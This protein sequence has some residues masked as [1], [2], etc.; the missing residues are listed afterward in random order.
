MFLH[1]ALLLIHIINCGR[2]KQH[3][4][5]NDAI[6]DVF[7]DL[8]LDEIAKYSKKKGKNGKNDDLESRVLAP[9]KYPIVFSNQFTKDEFEEFTTEEGSGFNDNF[10]F[11]FDFNL[12]VF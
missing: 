12:N 3:Q 4:A 8:Q 11:R 7:V 9:W 2:V 1:F 5:I 10:D 6:S